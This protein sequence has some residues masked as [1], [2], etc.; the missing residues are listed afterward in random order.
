MG[1]VE[2]IGISLTKQA[3][4]EIVSKKLRGKHRFYLIYNDFDKQFTFS[5]QC[6]HPVVFTR[7]ECKGFSVI[8]SSTGID[9]V[10]ITGFES[11][12]MRV[13]E[14]LYLGTK[15][16]DSQHVERW[17]MKRLKR[18]RS[19]FEYHGAEKM[20]KEIQMG[21]FGELKT[22]LKFYEEG[23]T[24]AVLYWKGPTR[25]EHDFV[26]PN[27]RYECKVINTHKNT[28]KIHGALQL[29]SEVPLV[30]RVYKVKVNEEGHS[31]HD[32]VSLCESYILFEHEVLFE[33]LLG[34]YGYISNQDDVFKFNLKEFIDYK[35]RDGFPRV[36]IINGI[37][38][39]EY[40][41]KLE[42]C[43]A[44]RFPPAGT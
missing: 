13:V 28:V 6:E 40:R 19:F 33:E 7:F 26:L 35:V 8:P 31:V 20:S 38:N 16:I 32:L 39:V 27:I 18:W 12:F 14:D 21:L 42:C 41:L 10:S 15:N 25:E 23:K 34:K 44:Y 5:Y 29:Y 43:E 2:R 4:K 37:D 11:V 22:L 9:C 36:P 17:I 24:D 1:I 3:N 30:L